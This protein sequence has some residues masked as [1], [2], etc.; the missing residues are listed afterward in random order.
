MWNFKGTLWNSTQNILLIHWKIRFLYNIGILRALRFKSPYAFLKRPPVSS[1]KSVATSTVIIHSF[2]TTHSKR[3]CMMISISSQR[4]MYYL[5]HVP[6]QIAK[7]MGLTWGPLGSCRPQMGL[8]LAP[9]T[10]YQ[11]YLALVFITSESMKYNRRK[12]FVCASHSGW[13][14]HRNRWTELLSCSPRQFVSEFIRH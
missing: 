13:F 2:S 3:M 5:V 6:C 8:M 12:R 11:E 10:C 4:R 1:P 14:T 9:W 7:F